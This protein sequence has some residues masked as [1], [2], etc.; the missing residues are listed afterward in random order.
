MTEPVT[1]IYVTTPD[2]DDARTIAQTI[3][4]LARALGLAIVAEGIE[5]EAQA[6]RLGAMGCDEF[7]GFLF[8]RAMPPAAFAALFAGATP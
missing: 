7:Q 4:T 1:L 2:E 6:D 5:T 3:V 8:A